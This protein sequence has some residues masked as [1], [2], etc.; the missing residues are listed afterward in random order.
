M[1]IHL[2]YDT[3][4]VTG[5]R[6]LE[7]LL[8]SSISQHTT[9]GRDSYGN[10]FGANPVDHMALERSYS[11]STVSSQSS[12]S[13]SPASSDASS[14]ASSESSVDS[15]MPIVDECE[16]WNEEVD[17]FL[18]YRDGMQ[19][20]KE[21]KNKEKIRRTLHTVLLGQSKR[22]YLGI[23]ND[24]VNGSVEKYERFCRRR[25]LD[26]AKPG[27]HKREE[28]TKTAQ[29]LASIIGRLMDIEDFRR[30]ARY[31]KHC[32]SE[33]AT[34]VLPY[35]GNDEVGQRLASILAKLSNVNDFEVCNRMA[36]SGHNLLNNMA[37]D[38]PSLAANSERQSYRR[39]TYQSLSS[40][41]E[42]SS[43]GDSSPEA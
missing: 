42:S 19:D 37:I 5:P 16:S 26:M 14:D 11:P 32:Y 2:R 17:A 35:V 21:H 12:R 28:G 18:A 34:D 40:M 4:Q 23:V 24:L 13:P 20:Q 31:R 27:N 6:D 38:M 29:H 25:L 30:I 1:T 9:E 39:S 33:I 41:P 43:S 15:S 10:K 3:A 22:Q 7:M 36:E 8:N